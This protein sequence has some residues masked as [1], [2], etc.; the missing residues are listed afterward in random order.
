MILNRSNDNDVICTK[1]NKKYQSSMELDLL[2]EIRIFY[3]DDIEVG[4][5]KILNG[6][7]IDIFLPKLNLGIE[8][9]GVYW[10]STQLKDNMYHYEKKKLGMEKGIDIIFIWEDDWKIDKENIIEMIKLIINVKIN[11]Q[12]VKLDNCPSDLYVKNFGKILDW[13][14]PQMKNRI[15]FNTYDSGIMILS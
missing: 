12:S 1:C 10:H 14:Y 5:K 6:K 15:G 8:F 4:N 2:N 9:N 3:K 11:N 7:E 13:K